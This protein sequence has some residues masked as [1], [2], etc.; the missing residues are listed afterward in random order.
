MGCTHNVRPAS[1]LAAPTTRTH[2][3]GGALTLRCERH[4]R[5]KTCGSVC[6]SSL[7]PSVCIRVKASRNV[8]K[9]PKPWK[10]RNPQQPRCFSTHPRIADELRP[11]CYALTSSNVQRARPCAGFS[12]FRRCIGIPRTKNVPSPDLTAVFRDF[13][14]GGQS[15]E[16]THLPTLGILIAGA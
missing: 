10:T 4:S 8:V 15:D 11:I 6:A 3:R 7:L 1:N 9:P 13:R 12:I 2:F 5:R 16:L 14:V